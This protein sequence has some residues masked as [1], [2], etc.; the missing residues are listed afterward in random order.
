M[1]SEVKVGTEGQVQPQCTRMWDLSRSSGWEHS[2]S[3]RRL[4]E[5]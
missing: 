1:L 3:Y 2:G 4:G 5:V